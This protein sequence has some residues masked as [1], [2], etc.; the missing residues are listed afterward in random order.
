MTERQAAII[1]NKVYKLI[2]CYP[3]RVDPALASRTLDKLSPYMSEAQIC[4]HLDFLNA[5]GDMV[6]LWAHQ[7]EAAS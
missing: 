4:K 2:N 1:A 7:Q 5:Y 3:M 6:R